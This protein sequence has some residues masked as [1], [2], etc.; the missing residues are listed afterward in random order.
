[1]LL[2]LLLSPSVHCSGCVHFPWQ[3]D[4]HALV[5]A[6][7]EHHHALCRCAREITRPDGEE[8]ETL[9]DSD[10]CMTGHRKVKRCC[11][12]QNETVT[13]PDGGGRLI[14]DLSTG[15]Q[16]IDMSV[17]GRIEHYH[18]HTPTQICCLFHWVWRITAVCGRFLGV[19]CGV[20]S[21]VIVVLCAQASHHSEVMMNALQLD[22]RVNEHTK[23]LFQILS[24]SN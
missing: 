13:A 11:W 17:H 9:R 21:A 15:V 10:S 19:D 16:L 23:T 2:P 6:G 3:H 18:S 8:R 5:E 20:R 12:S 7:T 1:M 14:H 4:R 24:L 22:R